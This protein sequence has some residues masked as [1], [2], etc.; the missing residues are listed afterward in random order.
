[1]RR[2]AGRGSLQI[3]WRF[4][5]GS[6]RLT[7]CTGFVWAAALAPTA[8]AADA[9]VLVAPSP[10]EPG[11]DIHVYARGCAGRTG[12]ASSEAFVADA[13]L[14]GEGGALAGETRVRSS[15]RPGGYRIEVTC[16]G[17]EGKTT[18]RAVLA[19]RS[20]AAVAKGSG[21]SKGGEKGS[22]PGPSAPLTAYPSPVAPVRAGGGGAAH[23]L[24]TESRELATESRELNTRDDGPGTRQAVIGLVLVSVAALAAVFR[25]VRRGREPE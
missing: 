22:G 3:V 24:A 20:R 4:T 8:Y 1:M 23:L 2:R 6:L 11:S 16:Y 21:A 10:P 7:L 9:D 14:T 19:V 12:T 15:V 5:M 13:V 25:G 18:T 17:V